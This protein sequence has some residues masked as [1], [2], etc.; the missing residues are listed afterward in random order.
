MCEQ[1]IQLQVP[2]LTIKSGLKLQTGPDYLTTL[3]RSVCYLWET[4]HTMPPQRD[5]CSNK[6]CQLC[7]PASFLVFHL[8]LSIKI[9]SQHCVD[10]KAYFWEAAYWKWGLFFIVREKWWLPYFD[11]LIVSVVV[12][13]SPASGMWLCQQRVAV[14]SLRLQGIPCTESDDCTLAAAPGR[15]DSPRNKVSTSCSHSRIQ[16]HTTEMRVNTSW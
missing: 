10:L 5:H 14:C 3:L 9:G 15:A 4:R 16:T 12:L 11:V 7:H 1:C 6:G 13:S 8:G 2:S